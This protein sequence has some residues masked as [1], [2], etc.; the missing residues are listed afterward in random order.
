MTTYTDK[1]PKP[2]KGRF[3]HFDHLTFWVGN[4]KQAASYYCSKMGFEQLAY[5][6]LETGSREVA[7]HVVKQNK[8]IFVFISPY[9]PG[10]REMGDHLVKHGDGVK[11][12]AFSVEDLDAIVKRC[13]LRGGELVRDIWEETDEGGT[14]RFATVKTFGDTTHTFADRSKYNGLFLP[15]YKQP[16]LKDKSLLKLPITGLDFVDHCV[17]NQPNDEMVPVSDWY[18]KSL[19]F[20]RFW[21][22]DDKQIHTE[23]SALRSIVVTNYEET[24]KMPINEPAPGKRKSQIQEYVD[25]YGGAGIQHIALNTKDII[26]AISNLRE[27]G[28]EFLTIPATYYKTLKENLKSAKIKIAED[29]DILQKLNIL[30]DYD[31]NGYLL[32]IFTKPMQ[33]RPTL[34]L[35]VIQRHNHQGFGAGNFKALFEAIEL[36]QAERG[37]L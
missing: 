11:D 18:E 35:E 37:N 34:F 30:I 7:A 19:M 16:L 26:K 25:Y 3:L 31:D 12:I 24:I 4:A 6:G 21:S 23:Y 13:K 2:D 20:H 33:D 10:N 17:G 32:Q 9:N 28:M 5:K 1:G 22:V 29:M 15:G 14:V 36:D 8:I 27:R